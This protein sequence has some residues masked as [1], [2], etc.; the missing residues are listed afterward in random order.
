MAVNEFVNSPMLF[1]HI[2]DYYKLKGPELFIEYM[3]NN[4]LLFSFENLSPKSVWINSTAAD[5]VLKSQLGLFLY[6]G[7]DG[8]NHPIGFAGEFISITNSC[9]NKKDAYQFV[10]LLLSEK[11]QADEE[12]LS[13]PVNRQAY[14]TVLNRYRGDEGNNRL[15]YNYADADKPQY[16]SIPLSD[17]IIK[18]M[19][20][21][22]NNM[23]SCYYIDANI[24]YIVN[25]QVESFILGKQ[26]SAQAANAIQNR[27]SIYLNE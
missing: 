11:F 15:I 3:K 24:L 23:Y 26:T 19:N 7:V 27:V 8:N 21:F 4:S 18:S 14:E 9:K 12:N 20:K 13:I 16:T 25:E 6:P 5:K 10:K 1:T 2:L 17:D 22:I